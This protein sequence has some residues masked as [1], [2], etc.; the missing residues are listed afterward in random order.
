MKCNF[1]AHT[2]VLIDVMEVSLLVY[3]NFKI[4]ILNTRPLVWKNPSILNPIYVSCPQHI[5]L[6]IFILIVCNGYLLSAHN[7][8]LDN[9]QPYFWSIEI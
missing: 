9:W 7:R 5:L 4:D 2:E 3:E 8:Q 6:W 1:V